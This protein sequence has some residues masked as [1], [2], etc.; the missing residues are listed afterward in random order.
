MLR[1]AGSGLRAVLLLSPAGR[2][3]ASLVD[4]GEGARY[5][6]HLVDKRRVHVT[7]GHGG[8]GSCLYTKHTKHHMIGPGWPCGGSGGKG[9]DVLVKVS[10]S[11]HS[12]AHVKG[13]VQGTSGHAGR[14]KKINGQKGMDTVI[15]VPRGVIVRELLPVIGTAPDMFAVAGPGGERPGTQKKFAPGDVLADLNED[16]E[17]VVIAE[18]GRGGRGNTMSKPHEATPGAPGDERWVELELKTIADVGLVGMP[19][20]G[21]ST[22][23]SAI[24]RA[25]PRIAPYPFTTVAPYVGQVEFTDGKGFTMADVPGLVE[26]AHQGEGL[27][28]EFLRHLERT[29]LLLYVIDVA[30]SEQP[31]QDFLALQRE[32]AR[33]SP[34]MAAKPCGIV[35]CKCDV[36][37]HNTLTQVDMLFSMVRRRGLSLE[38][39]N[40]PLFVRA[41]SARFGDGVKGLLQ[42]LRTILSGT[43]PQW[44]GRS[45]YTSC[46]EQG[47]FSSGP[48]R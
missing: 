37:P 42:E 47:N 48:A 2:S 30:H 14:K 15:S 13:D 32:V 27:G 31:F 39:D 29:Q 5:S 33:Y 21:K 3:A 8:N 36:E 6:R 11:H 16:G 22:L 23:L 35:A 40:L 46:G 34:A 9:G 41:I 20:A 28:H 45:G 25:T 44:P 17:I 4:R 10:T 19:N 26:N 12:L 38:E 43:H 24:S 18:G 7:A 1:G